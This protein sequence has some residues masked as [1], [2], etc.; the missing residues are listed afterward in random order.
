MSKFAEKTSVPVERSKAEIEQIIIRY[1]ATGFGSMWEGDKAVI[2]FK[3]QEKQLKFI[4]PL[5]DK[6]DERF[7][8]KKTGRIH[9]TLSRRS[10]AEA[11]KLWQQAC[12]QLW[13]A[14][15]LSVKAK[16]ESVESG[17]T[18]FEEEFLPHFVVPGD[19][20]TVGEIMVPQLTYAYE[21][22]NKLPPL[23]GSC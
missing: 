6:I 5:P 9:K 16:L 11:Y 12:R 4:L 2:I 22:N 23:L 3:M 14:L 7:T 15:L 13:R 20:R 21:N 10:E 1:G 8:I 18:S 19:G 17:I